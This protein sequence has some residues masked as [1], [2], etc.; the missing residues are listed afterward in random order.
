VDDFGGFLVFGIGL[1]VVAVAYVWVV[2]WRIRVHRSRKQAA[3]GRTPTPSVGVARLLT[4]EPPPPTAP[5]AAP[6]DLGPTTAPS[7]ASRAAPTPTP[8]PTPIDLGPTTEPPH[9]NVEPQPAPVPG[10]RPQPTVVSALAGVSLPCDLVPHV[11]AAPR[12]PTADHMAFW[13]TPRPHPE[14]TE[15][16]AAELRRLGYTVEPLGADLLGAVRNGYR[17]MVA[18]NDAG[19]GLPAESVA[20]EVW[21]PT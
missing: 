10:S 4:P 1:L 21:I 12:P 3:L 13:T 2:V 19:A 17:V 8:T 18:V 7:N 11:A 20:V 9:P 14:V 16:M 6:I 5:A 15:A